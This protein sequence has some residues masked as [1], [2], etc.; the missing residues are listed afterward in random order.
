M[1]THTTNKLVQVRRYTAAT[2][3]I[4]PTWRRQL[5]WTE[6]RH[7]HFV[8]VYVFAFRF[9]LYIVSVC[10]ITKALF[11]GSSVA[12]RIW[13][14]VFSPLRRTDKHARQQRP[15]RSPPSRGVDVAATRDK[16]TDG[17]TDAANIIRGVCPSVRL[18]QT[19]SKRR[20]DSLSVRPSFRLLDGVWHFM[21]TKQLTQ[22]LKVG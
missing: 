22:I 1:H 19:P 18:F 11:S 6:W 10:A 9:V 16:R 5:L 3:I 14:T 4:P 13:D 20:T 17:R 2:Y 12:G 8:T 7:C 21:S 15:P